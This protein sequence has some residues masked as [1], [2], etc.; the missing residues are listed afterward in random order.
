[1]ISFIINL[2]VLLSVTTIQCQYAGLKIVDEHGMPIE[3]VYI[4]HNKDFWHS[5]KNGIA[6]L[7]TNSIGQ[8]DSIS[9]SHLSYIPET[10]L[11]KDLKKDNEYLIFSLESDT[12][13]LT[14][15]TV[16][17]FDAKKYVEEAIKAIPNNYV[18][19]FE[20]NLKFNAD[21]SMKEIKAEKEEELIR[22]K[23]L[24]YLSL[25]KKDFY[26]FKQP[27]YE[28]ISPNLKKNIFFI[29][30]YD[31]LNI[32][33]I[34]KH[35]IIRNYKKYKYPRHEYLEY[36]DQ[37]A[38]KIYFEKGKRSGYL[39]IDCESKAILSINYNIAPTNSWIIGTMKGKGILKTDISKYFIEAE[40]IKTVSD[41]YIFDS[42]RENIS[43]KNRWKNNSISTDYNVYLKRE[44][45]DIDIPKRK[46]NIKDIF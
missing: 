25:E 22:Y 13:T 3:G 36:K 18:N 8:N 40:Y 14:E 11:F 16:S 6:K 20:E 15:V 32:I 30:P 12:K 9:F 17:A 24:L 31:F 10:I 27:E 44:T 5:D 46:T 33:P 21:I 26:V 39:I 41:K 35:H 45:G 2:I 43:S 34:K 7:N 23:G 19:P 29:K 1:M 4:K 42:G 38:V 37:N 28:L